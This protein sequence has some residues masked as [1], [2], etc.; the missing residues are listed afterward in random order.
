MPRRVPGKDMNGPGGWPR[1]CGAAF[2]IR[3]RRP[4]APA[5]ERPQSRPLPTQG[6]GTAGASFPRGAATPPRGH[7]PRQRRRV[8]LQRPAQHVSQPDTA[9]HATFRTAARPRTTR[10]AAADLG[11]SPRRRPSGSSM[12]RSMP[13][14]RAQRTLVGFQACPFVTADFVRFGPLCPSEPLM[15][16]HRRARRNDPSAPL[17]GA[18]DGEPLGGDRSDADSCALRGRNRR[19]HGGQAD[20]GPQAPR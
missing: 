19:G 6:P 14:D 17:R 8:V 7:A 15:S 2:A 13:I 10:R 5:R 1:R 20:A 12:R 18:C 16:D 9:R 11:V 3:H 4:P